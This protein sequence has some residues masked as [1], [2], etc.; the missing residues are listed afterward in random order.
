LKAVAQS[1]IAI[2]IASTIVKYSDKYTRES[3]YMFRKRYTM[4][5][6]E[7]IKIK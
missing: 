5:E 2:P 6:R 4:Q 7:I 1:G 3:T